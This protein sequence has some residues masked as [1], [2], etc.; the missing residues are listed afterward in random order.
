VRGSCHATEWALARCGATLEDLETEWEGPR[1]RSWRIPDGRPTEGNYEDH[2]KSLGYR[3]NDRGIYE[4]A[5]RFRG[6]SIEI[7]PA[8]WKMPGMLIIALADRITIQAPRWSDEALG[9]R[10][11]NRVA[12]FARFAAEGVEAFRMQ[13]Q[14]QSK[15]RGNVGHSAIGTLPA[16]LEKLSRMAIPAVN[17]DGPGADAFLRPETAEFT[18]FM[19]DE[20]PGF[21]APFVEKS[22]APAFADAF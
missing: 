19:L 18:R 11:H 21:G 12:D 6:E 9:Y 10:A 5:Q 7:M 1:A 14:L 8:D 16:G 17:H 3:V 22:G 2:L 4:V 20:F 15:H 13:D